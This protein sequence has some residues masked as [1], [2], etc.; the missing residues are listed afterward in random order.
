MDSIC[1]PPERS[2]AELSALSVSLADTLKNLDDATLRLKDMQASLSEFLAD[3]YQRVG[4]WIARLHALGITEPDGDAPGD[5]TPSAATAGASLEYQR[6][7]KRLYRRLA[8]AC[9]PDRTASAAKNIY[10]SVI[11]HAYQQQNLASLWKLSF[12]IFP[13]LTTTQLHT[14]LQTIRAALL[15]VQTAIATLEQ[16]NEYQLM[17]RVFIARLRGQDLVC[18]IEHTLSQRVAHE[19]RRATLAQLMAPLRLLRT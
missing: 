12:D 9:H 10:M 4:P 1:K 5:G 18:T 6:E 7:L 11:N 17:Q 15:E 19:E 16:S 3:Y 2:A 14:Q 8:Q 13:S